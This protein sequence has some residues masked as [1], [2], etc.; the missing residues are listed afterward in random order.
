MPQSYLIK[1]VF[2]ASEG[3]YDVY[4][5]LIES[6]LLARLKDVLMI[7]LKMLLKLTVLTKFLF[8]E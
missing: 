1:N 7:Y 8:L 4:D 2:V 3:Y 6:L 5:V